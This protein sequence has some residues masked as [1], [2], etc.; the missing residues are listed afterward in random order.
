MSN[1]HIFEQ[2]IN[3]FNSKEQAKIRVNKRN[4]LCNNYYMENEFIEEGNLD[5]F[6][7][8]NKYRENSLNSDKILFK[9][10]NIFVKI[11]DDKIEQYDSSEQFDKK[12]DRIQ[13]NYI[14]FE[15]EENNSLSSINNKLNKNN[16]I[17][18]NYIN[19]KREEEKLNNDSENIID[20]EIE[21]E[22]NKIENIKDSIGKNK[23]YKRYKDDVNIKENINIINKENNIKNYNSMTNNKKPQIKDMKI[24]LLNQYINEENIKINN[25]IKNKENS[26]IKEIEMDEFSYLLTNNKNKNKISPFNSSTSKKIKNDNSYAEKYINKLNLGNIKKKLYYDKK[27]NKSKITKQRMTPVKSNKINYYPDNSKKLE[28]IIDKYEFN[29]K[30]S[31]I[32]I[33]QC[34]FDLKIINQLIKKNQIIDLNIEKFKYII[35]NISNNQNKKLEELELLEQLW[36]KLNKSKQEYINSNLF[37]N[38]FQIIF[39]INNKKFDEYVILIENLLNKYNINISNNNESYISPLRNKNYDKSNLWCISKLIKIILKFKN[40]NNI[41]YNDLNEDKLLNKS[42]TKKKKKEYINTPQKL[43]KSLDY[44]HTSIQQRKKIPIYERLYNMRKIYKQDKSTIDS[45]IENYDFTPTIYSNEEFMNKSFTN[46]NKEKKPKGYYDYIIRNRAFLNKKESE[47]KLSEDKIYGK[48]YDKIKKMRIK[49]F[50]I[51]DLNG[52]KKFEN[53]NNKIQRHNYNKIIDKIYITMDIKLPN[54]KLESIKI[55]KDKNNIEELINALYIKYDL[56]DDKEK[57][58]LIEKIIEYKNSFFGRIITEEN[59]DFNKNEDIEFFNS[60]NN[61]NESNKQ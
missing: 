52:E 7:K 55:Y 57:K 1:I 6:N 44:N 5:I 10:K 45:D 26:D 58:N 18:S 46:Y 27:Q 53:K 59:N 31:I 22:N 35:E 20:D 56:Y 28:K 47:R 41:K 38:F 23:I 16:N 40:Q 42:T 29:K 19:K 11:N 8:N 25:D 15:K 39:S 14:S 48:N 50:N 33:V 49:P 37:F 61:S 60:N 43:N 13:E 17:N 9:E 2:E 21:E 32:N 34:L 12:E 30:L 4:N 36:F 24:K 54:G 3:E 51:T